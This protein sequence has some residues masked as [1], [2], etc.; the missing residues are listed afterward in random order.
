MTKLVRQR[1]V[2]DA[3]SALALVVANTRM[4]ERP[5]V[6]RPHS[7]LEIAAAIRA[8]EKGYGSLKDVAIRVGITVEMLRRFLSVEVL[9]PGILPLV[10]ARRIDSLNMVHYM[11]SLPRAD[12]PAVAQAITDGKLTGT[13]VRSL[14]PLRKRSPRADIET[15]LNRI[16]SSRDRTVYAIVLTPIRVR[17]LPSL[18]DAL[19]RAS[20]GGLVAIRRH[21]SRRFRAILTRMGLRRLRDAARARNT[22][23]REYVVGILDEVQRG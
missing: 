18:R 4:A 16:T 13:D 17:S 23:L 21:D 3:D 20:D 14:A 6:R 10:A 9:H 8:A 5:G 19:T 1:N 11:A 22:S 7:L 15:L 2:G 12:Q